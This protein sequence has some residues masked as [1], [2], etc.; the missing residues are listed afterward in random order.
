MNIEMNVKSIVKVTEAY[1]KV[2]KQEKQM[3]R[4]VNLLIYTK[5]QENHTKIC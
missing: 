5:Y 2:T 4:S 3:D 1:V